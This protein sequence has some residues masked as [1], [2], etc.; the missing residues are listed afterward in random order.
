MPI[1]LTDKT[2]DALP[3][4]EKGQKFYYDSKEARFGCR[5]NAGGKRSFILEYGNRAAGGEFRYTIGSRPEWTTGAARN[6]A[7]RLKAE[8]AAGRPPHEEKHKAKADREAKRV[9]AEAERL[10]VTVADVLD[11]YVA[12]RKV[13][14]RKRKA[15]DKTLEE[16]Q[17][18]ADRVLKPRIGAVKAAELAA[19]AVAALYSELQKMPR[20]IAKAKNLK[21]E[22]IPRARTQATAAM[23]FLSAAMA[24]AVG[25]GHRPDGMNPA[26]I[27]LEGTPKRDRVLF[28]GEVPRV[29]DAVDAMAADGR[30]HPTAV[31]AIRLLFATGCRASEICG[32]RWEYVDFRSGML[33]WDDTKTGALRKPMTAEARDLLEAAHKARVVGEPWVC[34]PLKPGNRNSKAKRPPTP[35]LRPDTL[36]KIFKRAMEEAGV[37]DKD[38]TSHLIRHWFATDT[39]GD[40]ELAPLKQ[41]VLVGHKSVAT[42]QR[43]AHFSDEELAEDGQGQAD[44]RRERLARERERGQVVPLKGGAA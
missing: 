15:K 20:R 25:A 31:L 3:V 39:Y 43:Y 28:T 44:R 33:R 36:G 27:E 11:G 21:A 41:M 9:A 26:R 22:D 1:L 30:L 37:T 35:H 7:K 4:P 2:V 19:P 13:D 12:S 42:A 38:A 23:R 17:R 24:W 16:Y 40:K 6:D 32:L 8:I 18:L 14:G 10:A 34:P 5:V 29:Q